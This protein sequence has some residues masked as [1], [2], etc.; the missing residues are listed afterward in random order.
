M[1]A[2]TAMYSDGPKYDKLGCPYISYDKALA[3]MS[4][5]N[6]CLFEVENEKEIGLPPRFIGQIDKGIRE[7]LD[8]D[9]L[10]HSE[11]LDGI[12]VA[13]NK[14][15]CLEMT[16][17]IHDETPFIFLKVTVKYMIFRP[18]IGTKLRGIVN[19]VGHGHLGCLVHEC[20]NASI[21][22]PTVDQLPKKL[23]KC[24]G[25]TINEIA[26]GTELLFK[27]IGLDVHND[28]LSIKGVMDDQDFGEIRYVIVF[29]TTCHNHI[30]I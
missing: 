13:Y 21:V 18:R 19:K 14:V 1:A 3:Y 29:S 25:E 8:T 9:L 26:F 20:F 23:K 12:I 30:D 16:G 17:S 10:K 28:V 2:Q 22:K 7:S 27:I 24:Y 6:S 15:Q 11:D 5:D 4:A